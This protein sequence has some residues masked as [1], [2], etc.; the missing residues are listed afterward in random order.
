MAQV[1]APFIVGVAGGT[2]SGKTFVAQELQKADPARI[3]ILSHDNYYK[4]H[5]DIPMEERKKLNYDEPAAL[6]QELFYQQVQAL[7]R[8]EAIEM[9]Q[10]DFMEHARKAQAVHVE[11]CPVVIIEGILILIDK[12]VRDLMDLTLFIDVDPDV[13]LARRLQRDVGTRDATFV[14][15]INQYMTS[16]QPMHELY[17]E[18]E[19]N[20]ADIIINNNRDFAELE[21][22][23]ETVRA[24][25]DEALGKC[26]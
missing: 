8:G 9:P 21:D 23:L 12:R 3:L 25:I 15:S 16:A 4:S 5:D 11:P 18:P 13:R 14:E 7:K 22:A 17:V 1:T 19:K 2:G 24:R 26:E 20:E 6:D 10:Y